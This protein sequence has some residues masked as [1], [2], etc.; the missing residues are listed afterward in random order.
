MV[1]LVNMNQD[2]HKIRYSIYDIVETLFFPFC[3]FIILYCLVEPLIFTFKY[4]RVIHYF[5]F[6]V[7]V[8][9]FVLNIFSK[10]TNKKLYKENRVWTILK[11]IFY[12]YFFVYFVFQ[13]YTMSVYYNYLVVLLYGLVV[14]YRLRKS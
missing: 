8:T 7:A 10:N 13:L 14:G 6:I 4:I 11:W 3:G 9:L 12:C 1:T 2:K 5:I